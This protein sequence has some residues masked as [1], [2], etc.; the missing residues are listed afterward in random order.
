[1][2]CP[3]C[4]FGY[5]E[6]L[7]SDRHMHR[8]I[9]DETM[10]GLRSLRFKNCAHASSHGG[11]SIIVVNNESPFIYRQL[12]QKVSLIAAGDSQLSNVA[13]AAR[14]A[15][16]ERNVHL[17]M[18]IEADRA[19]AYVCF[20]RRFRV[21]KCTWDEYDA[22]VFHEVHQPVWSIGFAWVSRAHRRKGWIRQTVAAADDLLGFGDSF[23]WYAPFTTDGEATVRALCPSGIFLVK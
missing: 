14:E 2:T 20:E 3:K 16:D 12:A 23:G 13:Y 15:L 5:V 17:F 19:R 1:V 9:H 6:S 4:G 7:A 10:H 18:G 8:R 21:W 11:R 22:G